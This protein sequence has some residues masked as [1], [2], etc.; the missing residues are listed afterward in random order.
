MRNVYMLENSIV[1]GKHKIYTVNYYINVEDM[2]EF[3]KMVK[4]LGLIYIKMKH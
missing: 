2:I 1:D 3:L 4:M